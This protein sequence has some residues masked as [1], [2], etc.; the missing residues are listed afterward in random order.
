MAKPSLRDELESGSGQIVEDVDDAAVLRITD[1]RLEFVSQLELQ[2]T[3]RKVEPKEMIINS[4][5][6]LSCRKLERA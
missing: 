1:V 3:Q 4:P 5:D 6:E 2:Y